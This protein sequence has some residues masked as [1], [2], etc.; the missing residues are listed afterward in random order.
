MKDQVMVR[1]LNVKIQKMGIQFD[2]SRG[3]ELSIPVF[4]GVRQFGL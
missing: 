1:C 3:F 4:G 2:V